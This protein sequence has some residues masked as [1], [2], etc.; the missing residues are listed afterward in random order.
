VPGD[1]A[2]ETA[3]RA[4]EAFAAQLLTP[5]QA[6][7]VAVDVTAKARGADVRALREAT[8]ALTLQRMPRPP[9]ARSRH[10]VLPPGRITCTEAIELLA[11][12]GGRSARGRHSRL[13]RHLLGCEGCRAVETRLASAERAFA[14]VAEDAVV[15]TAPP[16]E[17]WAGAPTPAEPAAPADPAPVPSRWLPGSAL[18][19]DPLGERGEADEASRRWLPGA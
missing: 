4:V 5:D 6:A 16:P 2:P 12:P 7:D 8:R 15:A 9:V 3:R 1:L 18:P 14:R 17:R 19:D 10:R 11:D 13:S